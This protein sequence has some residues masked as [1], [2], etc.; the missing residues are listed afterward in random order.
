[1]LRVTR[2]LFT[3]VSRGLEA[4]LGVADI[5]VA[6]V[7]VAAIGVAQSRIPALIDMLRPRKGSLR[8]SLTC[9]GVP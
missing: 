7:G 4:A 9:P 6:E 2:F 8:L 1:M 5:G 3:Y